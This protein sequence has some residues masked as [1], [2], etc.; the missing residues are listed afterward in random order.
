LRKRRSIAV[1]EPARVDLRPDKR[2]YHFI[3]CC[4]SA[5]NHA[6]L[7]K[8]AL[9]S[10]R[11][12]TPQFSGRAPSCPAR[13]VCKMKWRTCAAHATPDHGP[14]QLHVMRHHLLV[15]TIAGENR[16]QPETE[17]RPAD[18]KSA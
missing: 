6:G 13:R 17:I 15:T 2:Q 16:K 18:C 1:P 3:R 8:E 4:R 10:N 9:E 11:R 14:L 5:L 12:I 7:L